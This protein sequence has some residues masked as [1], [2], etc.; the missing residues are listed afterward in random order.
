MIERNRFQI[1]N[2]EILEVIPDQRRDEIVQNI[3]VQRDA[4]KHCFI[5]PH[6]TYFLK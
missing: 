6:T 4:Q 1:L 2:P 5:Y 3:H